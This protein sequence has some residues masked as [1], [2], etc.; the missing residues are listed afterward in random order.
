MHKKS[1]IL[2]L[3][4]CVLGFIVSIYVCVVTPDVTSY[5][6]AVIFLLATIFFFFQ[7]KNFPPEK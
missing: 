4:V 3:V 7:V 5:A 6:L 2:S 1:L